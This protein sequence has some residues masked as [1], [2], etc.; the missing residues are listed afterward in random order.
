MAYFNKELD[1]VKL[2]RL[3][4]DLTQEIEAP[5][6]EIVRQLEHELQKL[7]Q[8]LTKLRYESNFQK[9]SGENERAEHHNFIEQLRMKHE[10]E[11]SAIKKDRDML[12]V[13]LQENNQSEVA[14][15]KDVIRENN[16]LKIKVRSLIEENEETR[17]KINNLETHNNAL[18]RNQS[19]IVSDY[20]T[21]IAMLEVNF[22]NF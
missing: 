13:K 14:K 21:K 16:Q 9:S 3:R 8:E 17:E 11:L 4:E 5:Y 20:T 12:R 6:K 10:I 15:I 22:I 7:Q 2:D 18:V 19:K 1:D